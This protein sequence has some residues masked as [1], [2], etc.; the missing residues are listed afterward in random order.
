MEVLIRHHEDSEMMEITQGGKQ[1]FY[2]NYWDFDDSPNG[3]KEFLKQL[4]I[5]AKVKKEKK[6]LE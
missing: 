3:L 4:G 5:K 6:E 2:G 1:I